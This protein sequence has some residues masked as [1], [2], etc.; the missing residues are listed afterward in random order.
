MTTTLVEGADS[1]SVEPVA[2]SE[3]TDSLIHTDSAVSTDSLPASEAP[4]V[5]APAASDAA[6]EPEPEKSPEANQEPE[7]TAD[8]WKDRYNQRESAWQKTQSE[9]RQARESLEE[10]V[11]E[12]ANRDEQSQLASAILSQRDARQNQ[13]LDSGMEEA[14]ALET[15]NA[16][17]RSNVDQYVAARKGQTQSTELERLRAE[18]ARMAQTGSVNHIMTEYGVPASQ[19]ALLEATVNATQAEELA[20]ALGKAEKNRVEIERLTQAQVPVDGETQQVDSGNGDG[21]MTDDQIIAAGGNAGGTFTDLNALDAAMR[22]K[23]IHP[24]QL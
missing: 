6:S 5:E 22:R 20:Q 16:E 2:S 18:N 9:E 4:A 15:A 14:Q 23:G 12:S 21:S 7:L 1:A 8:E 17:A 3:P 24:D 11:T 19:R 13:L 10:K